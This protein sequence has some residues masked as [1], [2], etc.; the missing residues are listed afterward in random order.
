MAIIPFLIALFVAP[1]IGQE[2]NAPARISGRV[3]AAETG[4]PLRGAMV[5][6]AGGSSQTPPVS[7]DLD[8]RFVLAERRI[9]RY[10]LQVSKPGY[11][12]SVFG[13]VADPIDYFEVLAGQRIDRG[14]IR[15]QIATVI[16][17][18][19]HD[20]LGEPVADA[21]VIVWRIEFPQ[22]GVRMWRQLKDT[23]TN[24]LGEFRLH[25][26]VPGRYHVVA[27]RSAL[28]PESFARTPDSAAYVAATM[29]QSAGLPNFSEPIAVETIRG[30]ETSGT[31]I[32]LPHT[33]YARVSGSVID[34]TGRPA[35][36][37]SVTLSPANSEALPGRR[38]AQV[39]G[40]TGTFTFSSVP[41]GEYRLTVSA[42]RLTTGTFTTG[43]AP[44]SESVSR[45][46]SIHE[47]LNGL[48]LQTETEIRQARVLATGRVFLDGTPVAETRVQAMLWS[49]DE[50]A[51]APESLDVLPL[52]RGASVTKADGEFV[53]GA[54]DGWVVLRHAGS[55]VLAL[56]SVTAGGV[57][58]TDGFEMKRAA[59]SYEVHLTSQ[60]SAISGVVKDADGGAAAACD[61]V[62]FAADPASW[63]LPFSR[64]MVLVRAN[65]KGEF[66]V[67]GLPGG[68]YLV[69][70]PADLDR[71]MWA[72]PNRLERWR[73]IAT[74]LSISD[75]EK[76][77]IALRRN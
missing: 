76:T 44:L 41:V 36:D 40:R 29:G 8:G 1:A 75:G 18:R 31:A 68:Q 11:V 61:V 38:G 10:A 67:T 4:Q 9:G 55:S 33:R 30:G 49:R 46:I 22:P 6:L 62:V 64:R 3:L 37:A 73:A 2:L 15:L 26:L 34:S 58:V 70:A 74:P 42:V 63:K 48:V 20:E 59:S 25:G 69:A 43:G 5:Q 12:P 19:V 21:S 77:T 52:P 60:V 65:E 35:S 13:R 56:K 45:A 16:S 32:T 50:N 7:T 72:D 51:I 23:S 66:Q 24:D 28:P 14:T 27:S 54:V 57:D 53:F 71:A 39:Y 47:D 17:G